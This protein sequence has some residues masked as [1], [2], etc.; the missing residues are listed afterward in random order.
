MDASTN[1]ALRGRAYC[2]FE[3]IHSRIPRARVLVVN[4]LLDSADH[5]SSAAA[6]LPG[7]RAEIWVR[8]EQEISRRALANI[9]N[10]VERLVTEPEVKVIHLSELSSTVAGQFDPDAIV[11]SGTLRDF[12]LYRPDLIS[13]FGEFIRETRYPVL[14][15]CGGHQLIGECLGARVTTLD[16]K[17]P[18]EKR[19]GRIVEY[20]YRL[21]KI[22]RPDDP[23]FAGVRDHESERWQRYTKRKHVLTVW[24]NHGLKIDRLPEGFV[25]LAR[26]YLTE[27][28]M[29]AL[30]SARQLIYSVQFHIEK[31][32]E[33]F[34]RANPTAWEHRN[35][36]RDGRIIFENFLIEALKWKGSN[37]AAPCVS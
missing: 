8:R 2:E 3:P 4:D 25:Q 29:M 19:D 33:D 18:H 14:G 35:Q 20:Q 7:F 34:D 5:F 6:N 16:D 1:S 28:Q 10:N 13:N 30:R 31:S 22:T 9:V 17:L 36:S 27:I 37:Q 15:I 11:L 21:V 23:I 12:D 24:Q 26:S 32:F